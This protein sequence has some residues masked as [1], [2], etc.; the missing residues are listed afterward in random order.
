ML[1]KNGKYKKKKEIVSYSMPAAMQEKLKRVTDKKGYKFVSELIRDVIDK[2]V[3]EDDSVIPVV[4]KV[5]AQLVANPE[6]LKQWFDNRTPMVV[7]ALGQLKK[8][9]DE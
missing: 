1:N 7:K 9:K 8:V 6:L 5:P 3:N 4:L 2:Y